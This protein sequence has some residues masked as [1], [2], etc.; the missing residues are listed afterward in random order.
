MRNLLSLLLL[1][2]S[3]VSFAQLVVQGKVLNKENGKPIEYANIGIVNSSVG[4]ISNLDGSFSIPVPLKHE[5]DSLTFSSV[6]FATQKIPVKYF[7]SPQTIF[8]KEKAIPLTQVV[9]TEKKE[10]LKRY[11]VGNSTFKGGVL[12]TDTTYAGGATALLID[13]KSEKDAQFPLYIESA[14]LRILRNNLASCKF[15]VRLNEV[16][17]SGAPGND[18]LEKSVVA[19]SDMRNGWM[20]FDL[21]PFQM[22]MTKPFFVTFEQILDVHDR[23]KIADGYRE[24]MQEHPEKLRIDTVMFDGKKEVIKTLRGGIDLP[25]TFIAINGS[26]ADEFTCYSRETSFGAWTKVRGIVTA[27]VTL[28]TQVIRH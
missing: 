20:E 15:R 18:L 27:T 11:D 16:D 7:S 25:G 3:Q 17:S 19:E 21:T 5:N 26:K 14:Q 8:L 6:G 22:I 12:E 9:I 23:T 10:K 13:L 4:S 28:T 1:F 24:Y 2:L